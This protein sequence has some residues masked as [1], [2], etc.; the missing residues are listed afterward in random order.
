[1][2]DRIG[3]CWT[4]AYPFKGNDMEVIAKRKYHE[5]TTFTKTQYNSYQKR[6]RFLKNKNQDVVI[7][8][9]K[10]C[11]VDVSFPENKNHVVICFGKYIKGFNCRKF[12]AKDSEILNDTQHIKKILTT[13]RNKEKLKTLLAHHYENPNKKSN[14]QIIMIKQCL[15]LFAE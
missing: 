4:A 11:Q 3:G 8:K 6:K 10:F 12:I 15:S 2:L 14:G 5:P 7:G 1:M 9:G 13:A